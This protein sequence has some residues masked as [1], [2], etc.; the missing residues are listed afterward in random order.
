MAPLSGDITIILKRWDSDRQS[1]VEALTPIVYAELHKI[2][3]AYLRRQ[4]PDHTLQ[5]TALIHEAY[6]RLVRQESADIQDRSH[7]YA[8]AARMMRQILVDGA[9]AVHAEKRGSGN[10]VQLD[11]RVELGGSDRTLDLIAIHEALEKLSTHNNRLAQSVEL[12][13][14]GGLQLDEIAAALGI[15]LATVK[16]DLTLAEAFLR[17]A[18]ASA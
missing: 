15:S 1:A 17:R 9:R 14:F 2:A 12:R 13:Y 18:L 7:F 3:A 6:L 5:P 8:L 10:K 11:E 4:R 16:R